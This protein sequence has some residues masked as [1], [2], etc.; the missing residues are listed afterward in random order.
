MAGE[1][2]LRLGL[3]GRFAE[4]DGQPGD[5]QAE[6]GRQQQHARLDPGADRDGEQ[7][8]AAAEE[9]RD[10]PEGDGVAEVGGGEVVERRGARGW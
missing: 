5:H 10:Q 4:A 7:R 1:E 3:V 2:D 9:R 8:D 6:H